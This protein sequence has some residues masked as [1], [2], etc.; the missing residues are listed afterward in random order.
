MAEIW[1]V[2]HGESLWNAEG[3]WQGQGDPPL[4]E[5]GLRQAEAAAEALAGR[6]IALLAASDLA[7]ARATAEVIGARLGLPPRLEADLR[8]LDVG[9]WSG[10]LHAEIARRW[11]AELARFRAGDLEL[12]PGGG[13][14]RL[15]LGARARRVLA[16]LAA[17]AEGP[18]AVVSHLG[19]L[20][21]LCPG[22]ELAPGELLAL[23][24]LARF[25]PGRHTD[26]S[27]R[28]PH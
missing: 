9:C 7:R 21:T 14:S 27:A 25:A 19:L 15:A 13:E 11:P 24:P 26:P 12:A 23:G 4:S 18:L 2:R 28:S 10:L 5:R 6:G 8:E 3:R 22:A 20:R 17:L 1:F 16:E